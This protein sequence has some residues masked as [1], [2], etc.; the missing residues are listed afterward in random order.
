[1]LDYLD[2]WR[3]ETTPE[4][5]FQPKDF[6]SIEGL[7]VLCRNR[8]Q[9]GEPVLEMAFF[10]KQLR[11]DAQAEDMAPA[12]NASYPLNRAVQFGQLVPT[13]SLVY[14]H[15]DGGNVS[16]GANTVFRC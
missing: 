11:E 6:R 10:H 4:L 7:A 14:A 9:H 16:P 2:V 5:S 13:R 15:H 1:M 12:R 8:S 3:R